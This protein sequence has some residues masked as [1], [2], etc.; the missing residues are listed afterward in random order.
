[1][2]WFSRTQRK[3]SKER[4][5]TSACQETVIQASVCVF[6]GIPGWEWL[7]RFANLEQTCQTLIEAFDGSKK[8]RDPMV[9]SVTSR[10]SKSVASAPELGGAADAH[11]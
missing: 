8:I 11:R 9:P 5:P 10:K 4:K 6:W 7:P 1:M 2:L 3:K